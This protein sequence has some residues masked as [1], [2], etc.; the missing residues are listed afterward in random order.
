[1]AIRVQEPLTGAAEL[2][3]T[4]S[5]AQM[6]LLARVKQ[7]CGIVDAIQV[8]RFAYPKMGLRQAK[9]FCDKL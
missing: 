7:K 5:Y 1:M 2:D 9:D 6:E 4:I 8:L 3:V